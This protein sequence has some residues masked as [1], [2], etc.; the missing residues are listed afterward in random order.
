M[1]QLKLS[2][3]IA[4]RD[5]GIAI[6]HVQR[7]AG[8]GGASA[9]LA[10]GGDGRPVPFSLFY[11]AALRAGWNALDCHVAALLAMTRGE[12]LSQ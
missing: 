8:V 10:V 4:R 6:E 5:N 7:R 1:G 12:R 2:L 3:Q 9:F 11:S